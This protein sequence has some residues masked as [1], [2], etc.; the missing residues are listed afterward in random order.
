MEAT[1]PLSSLGNTPLLWLDREGRRFANEERCYSPTPGGNAILFAKRAFNVLDQA[2]VDTLEANGSP[3][4]PWRGI[5]VDTPLEGLSKELEE[6]E[7]NGYV[8]S[9]DQLFIAESTARVHV[10]H[11]YAKLGVHSKQELQHLVERG[12]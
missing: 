12:R 5:K 7:S 2:T 11:V 3:I 4:R 6:G 9:A 8:F 10:K 1:N